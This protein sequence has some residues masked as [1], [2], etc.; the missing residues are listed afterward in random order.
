MKWEEVNVWINAAP[1]IEDM[2]S[3]KSYSQLCNVSLTDQFVSLF[4]IIWAEGQF[5]TGSVTQTL[6]CDSKI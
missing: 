4:N 5:R 6:A 3:F 2:D 1:S